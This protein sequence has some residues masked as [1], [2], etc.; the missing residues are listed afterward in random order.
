MI[1]TDHKDENLWLM[2]GDCLERMKEIPDGSVD[3][4]LCDLPYGTTACKWDT[5]IPFEPLWEQYKRIITPY[6]AIVLTGSQPFTTAVISSNIAMFKYCWY[7][8]K[9][10]GPNFALTGF[11]PLK[12]IE[13]IIVFSKGASTFTKN[14]NGMKYNPQKTPLEKPYKR[15]FTKNPSRKTQTLV[16]PGK[17]L[18]SAEYT[19]ATPRNLLYAS[20][21][22]D[23]RVHPT[24]KP[25][26]LMEYLIRTYTNEGETV[27]DNTM[28]SGTTGVAC[29]NTNRNF[30]GIEMDDTYFD[31]AKT[32]ILESEMESSTPKLL[33]TFFE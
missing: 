31:I 12:V 27:L 22:G 23:K 19:H 30:V 16:V 29:V 24:Q 20:T 10:K 17:G 8:E 15:D 33:E 13:E 11:Q 3:M 14:G 21:D 6:G 9:P 25:V 26:A 4:I 28:G 2:K 18:D 7:W 5:I 1:L 32:R